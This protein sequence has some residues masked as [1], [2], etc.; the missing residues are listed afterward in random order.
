MI[1]VLRLH[2]FVCYKEGQMLVGLVIVLVTLYCSIVCHLWK[3]IL[4]VI[5]AIFYF[6]LEIEPGALIIYVP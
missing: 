3:W 4:V 5:W 1:T 2:P 6:G